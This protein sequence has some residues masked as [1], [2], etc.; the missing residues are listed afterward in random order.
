MCSGR[1]GCVGH[2]LVIKEKEGNSFLVALLSGWARPKELCF[3]V[4]VHFPLF[5]KELPF[6]VNVKLM[7]SNCG[8]Y[9][10]HIPKMQNKNKTNL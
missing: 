3:S 5:F 6:I 2:Q 8:Q 7:H 1:C 4:F 10:K 9:G